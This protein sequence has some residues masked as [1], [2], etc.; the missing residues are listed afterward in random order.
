MKEDFGCYRRKERGEAVP[1]GVMASYLAITNI[2]VVIRQKGGYRRVHELTQ[3]ALKHG[4]E[5]ALQAFDV[6][7][8]RKAE[9]QTLAPASLDSA[10]QITVN[11]ES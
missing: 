4:E 10:M 7:R 8:C 2:S 6:T 3:L 1:E 5:D 9:D 11:R